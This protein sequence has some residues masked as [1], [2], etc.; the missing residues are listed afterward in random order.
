MKKIK[1]KGIVESIYYEKLPN[2]LEVFL[3][4][5]DDIYSNYVTFTTKYGSIYNE[6]IP[7]DSEKMIKVPKGIAHFLEHKVFAQKE[8]PQ[9]MEFF[10]QSGSVCNAYTTFNNTTYLFYATEKLEENINYLLDYVQELYLTDE[11]VEAE[12]GNISEE[13]HMYDDRPSEVLLEKIRFNT[14]LD[15]P[16]RDSIIATVSDIESITKSDLETCYNTFY[17]P[18]N[19]F[20]VVT[21]NFDPEKIMQIIRENQEKKKFCDQKEIVVKEIKEPDNVFKE[22]EEITIE[23]NVPKIAYTIK[24]P[25]KNI[26]LSRRKLHL[27]MHILFTSLF[28]E[29]STFDEML[30]NDGIITTTTY[31]NM[32]NCDTHMLLSIINETNKYEDFLEQVKERLDKLTIT[33]DDFERKKKVLI[34]NQIFAYEAVENINDIIIDN[35]IFN[36]HIEDDPIENI[37]SLNLEELNKLIE[38]IN[39]K[40]TSIVILKNE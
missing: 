29:T 23:T 34:S 36:G 27:Y 20:L 3:Y 9:P 25:L 35:I 16:Y 2:G 15:N 28:D 19:M 32:L 40:N 1:I 24:I 21:G 22:K 5:K 4:A 12:K 7:I 37:K 18:A 30:K 8:D 13:I 31:I 14:L 38:K 10:A 11:S 6:F 33:N 17:H 26:K 39:I